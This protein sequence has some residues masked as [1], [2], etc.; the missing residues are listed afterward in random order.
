MTPMGQ[1][2]ATA[3]TLPPGYFDA[4]AATLPRD[5]SAANT[6]HSRHLEAL[7]TYK[8]NIVDKLSALLFVM[9]RF[10]GLCLTV[11]LSSVGLKLEQLSNQEQQQ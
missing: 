3:A 5:N 7:S 1:V 2:A 11:V 8:D 6:E 4:W 9:R 10:L